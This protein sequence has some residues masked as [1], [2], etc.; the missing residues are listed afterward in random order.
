M[1]ACSKLRHSSSVHAV[2]PSKEIQR[3]T[4]MASELFYMNCQF[5]LSVCF[6]YKRPLT[7]YPSLSQSL[8]HMYTYTQ[9]C[10]QKI[11]GLPKVC[12]IQIL[13]KNQQHQNINNGFFFSTWEDKNIMFFYHLCCFLNFLNNEHVFF[14]I[15]KS[16]LLYWEK[17]APYFG[18]YIK[19]IVLLIKDHK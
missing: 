12:T 6:S 13:F 5:T 10:T 9:F 11:S 19:M 3:E 17:K 15:K 8:S 4:L 2:I 16:Y 1:S 14:Q 7:N 18:Y